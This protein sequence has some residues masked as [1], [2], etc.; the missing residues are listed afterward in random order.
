[1]IRTKFATISTT[2]YNFYQYPVVVVGGITFIGFLLRLT[3]LDYK[4]LWLD[5][6]KLYWI[7]QG[8]IAEVIAQN[9]ESNSAPFLFAII[10]NLI[11][12]IDD[13]EIFLRGTSWLAGV[14][15]IPLIYLLAKQFLPKKSAYFV[16]FV[17]AVASTQVRYSQQLREYSMAFLLAM[18]ILTTFWFFLQKPNW[19]RFML[20]I[21]TWLTGIFTQYGLAL[22]AFSLNIVFLFEWLFHKE[23]NIRLL[24]KWIAA[25][26][27]T[28]SGVVLIYQLALKSQLRVGFGATPTSNY[29][30]GAYWNGSLSSIVDFALKN[31]VEIFK[32]AYPTS[33]IFNYSV[34]VLFIFIASIGFITLLI[35]RNWTVLALLIIPMVCTLAAAIARLYPY[36]GERQTIFLLP[37]IYI[38]IGFGFDYLLKIDRKKVAVIPLVVI[39]GIGG[40]MST[41]DYLNWQGVENIKPIVKM[42][43]S[44]YEPGDEIYIYY[45]AR[46]AFSYYYRDNG[47]NWIVGV[48]GR[49]QPEKY[50]R[51]LDEELLPAQNRVWLVFSHCFKDECELIQNHTS[52]LRDTKLIMETSGAWLYL[53]D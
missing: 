35:S 41:Y 6:A 7:S 53:A 8:N 23:R 34:E 10:I 5:E 18:L 37:M 36:H 11:S 27:I 4:S 2:I 20:L 52:S 22:L 43:S 38:L 28:L 46:Y 29:L 9:A 31:T 30:Q 1:M 14:I 47:D 32:F 12:R 17:V 19:I 25:Q 48:S 45:G 15:A 49:D 3:R 13:T 40:L 50:L 39:L 21:I 26:V 42:L 16:A 24:T 51:Q 33:D 44:S